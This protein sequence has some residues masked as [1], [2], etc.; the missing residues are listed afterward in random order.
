MVINL[1]PK[2]APS[3]TFL[4]RAPMSSLCLILD[5]EYQ[6]KVTYTKTINLK[7]SKI[8]IIRYSEE[9]ETMQGGKTFKMN[10][11]ISL[12]P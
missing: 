7:K 4:E 1:L 5:N 12:H 6:T 2:E 10:K 3:L 8:N 9:T 11:L